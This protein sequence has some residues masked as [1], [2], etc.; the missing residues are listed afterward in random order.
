MF[1]ESFWPPVKDRKEYIYNVHTGKLDQGKKILF[2][3]LIRGHV[4]SLLANVSS[5]TT[6]FP[7]STI[8]VY[9]NDS[10]SNKINSNMYNLPGF[11]RVRYVYEEFEHEPLKQDKGLLRRTRMALYRN[12]VWELAKEENEKTNF[13]YLCIADYDLLGGYSI[14]GIH[15][16]ISKLKQK[17]IIGANSLVYENNKKLYYDSWAYRDINSWDFA[18][19]EIN[20]LLDFKRGEDLVEVNSCFGGMC[21]YPI[22]VLDENV[23][24]QSYD[25]DHVTLHK[26]LKNRGYKVYLNPSLITL[27]SENYYR[28]Y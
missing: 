1:P 14:E 24:Y 27:Y 26:Q 9:E 21:F 23:E 8:M 20:N 16:T 3:G 11:N 28:T 13:D 5:L 4:N 15:H 6:N 25:C 7:L 10:E 18:G 12:K 2:C 17:T 22:S 19:D